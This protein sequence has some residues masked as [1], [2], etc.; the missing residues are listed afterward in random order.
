MAIIIPFPGKEY[1]LLQRRDDLLQYFYYTFASMV[2]ENH[3]DS[4]ELENEISD[5]F[6]SIENLVDSHLGLMNYED[7][8]ERFRESNEEVQESLQ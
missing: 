7:C 2:N 6:V 8:S 3:M 1:N 5:I 4:D